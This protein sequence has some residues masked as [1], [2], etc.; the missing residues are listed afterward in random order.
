LYYKSSKAVHNNSA[1]TML[2]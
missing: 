1:Q 2:R